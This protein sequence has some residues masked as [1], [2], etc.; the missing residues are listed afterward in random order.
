M[1]KINIIY[2]VVAL[3]LALGA[4]RKSDGVDEGNSIFQPKDPATL[5]AFDHWITKNISYPYN[6]DI[7]YK[8]T[9]INTDPRFILTPADIDKSQKM[10]QVVK[11]AWLEAYDEV[12]GVDFTRKYAPKQFMFVG[13]SAF[14]SGNTKV[15]AT[16][17]GGVKITM[18]EINQM[19]LDAES[20]SE[21]YFHVIH[22]EFSHILHQTKNYSTDFQKISESDYIKDDWASGI[23]EETAR[24]KGFVS[25]YA[26]SEPNE[27]FAE[28]YSR[29]I[30]STDKK[31]AALLAPG[32]AEGT[33]IINK[34]LNIIRE[35]AR[36]SWGF[37]LDELRA[38]VL[39]R[40]E[41]VTQLPFIEF[42]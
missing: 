2:F 21:N 15:L 10:L 20:L 39:R 29:F 31:W 27:D 12:L 9:D 18:Y 23:T 17:E 6:I 25:A 37:E 24:K 42:N 16:A 26:M 34:K 5:T 36:N 40:S 22:H 11:Y 4:C 38:V 28:T 3:S 32:G 8:Y 19:K 7:L 30:T 35:Y 14:D 1:K 33:A 41:R 13:S